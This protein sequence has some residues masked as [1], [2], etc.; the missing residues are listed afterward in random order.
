MKLTVFDIVTHLGGAQRSTAEFMQRIADH[1]EVSYVDAYGDCP[2]HSHWL[3]RMA[4]QRHVLLPDAKHTT[5]G[6]KGRP[7]ARALKILLSTRELLKVRKRL[8]NHLQSEQP[9]VILV[10]S[11]K[12]LRLLMS[13]GSN[14]PGKLVYWCRTGHIPA[15]I[16]QKGWDRRVDDFWCL[17]RTV[18][19]NSIDQGAPAD[20]LTVVPNV[21]E[22]DKMRE[23]ASSPLDT[24]LPDADKPIRMAVIATLLKTKGQDCAIR[25]L[26]RVVQAGHDAVLYLAGDCARDGNAFQLELEQLAVSLGVRDRVHLLGWRKDVPQIITNSTH[27]VL[28][29]H[30]EGMP[31]AVME[32]MAQNVPVISTPVGS[33]PEMLNDGQGGWLFDIDDDQTLANAVIDAATSPEHRQAKLQNA[34]ETAMIRYTKDAQIRAAMDAFHTQIEA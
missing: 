15:I 3:D 10:I 33:I 4:I 11:P 29:T 6:H 9:D 20:K 19:Q 27:M 5:I 7:F 1:V 31:R 21:I 30:S 23:Q 14:R 34:H 24:P 25:A 26:A 12:S 13:L 22:V 8:R 16:M 17:S 32:A 28:P 2:E 18:R